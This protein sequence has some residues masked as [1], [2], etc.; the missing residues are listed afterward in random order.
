LFEGH[1]NNLWL[2]EDG[3]FYTIES[4]IDPKGTFNKK[5][6]KTPLANASFYTK[7]RCIVNN[8]YNTMGNGEVDSNFL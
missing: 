3:Y 8:S 6:L 5:W 1:A 4:T 7:T 2:H